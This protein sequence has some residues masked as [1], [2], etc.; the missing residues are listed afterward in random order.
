[1]INKIVVLAVLLVF[2]ICK[3]SSAQDLSKIKITNTYS[4]YL[5]A[6]LLDIGSKSHVKFSYDW[7]AIHQFKFDGK[8]VNAP[9]DSILNGMCENFNLKYNIDDDIISITVKKEST[10]EEVKKEVIIEDKRTY[11]GPPKTFNYT[12]SGKVTDGNTGEAL[13]YAAI[14][15]PGTSV[16]A[17]TNTDGYF[18]LLK[19]PTDTSALTIS[20]MGYR[21]RKYFLTPETSKA[22]LVIEILPANTQLSTV[23]VK[24]QREELMRT[25]TDVGLV[26]ISP[27]KIESLPSLGE[28]DIM[29]SL[30][31]MPGITASK[32]SSSG[33]YVWGGTPDQNLILYDGFTVYHV[34]HLYGFFS[35]FNS[36]AIKD[37]QL[38]KGGFES[39]F[40]GRLSSVTEI[41]GKD[42]NQKKFNIGGDISLLSY[43]AYIETPIGK[44]ITFL[45]AGRKSWKGPLYNEIFK[46]FNKSYNS[47]RA[48]TSGGGYGSYGNRN[49]TASTITS[50]FYDLNSKITYRP[51]DK[52][53]LSLSLYNGTDNLDNSRKMSA[54]SFMQSQGITFN[55][56]NSDLTKSGNLGGSLKWS[57]KWSDYLY[58][59]TLISYSNY[60]YNRNRSNSMTTTNS[61]G[62]TKTFQSGT[63]ETNNLK[64]YSF[65]SDYQ[66]DVFKNNKIEFGGF[67]TY[68]D[69]SYKYSQNDTTTILSR[70]DYGTNGG[71]YL[72]D[73][74]QF[75][76]NKLTLL[77]GVRNTYYS[78]TNKTY[79]EPRFSI[80]YNLTNK[81]Q[82]KGAIGQYYQF[83]NKVSFED[84][85][86]GNTE[87]WLLSNNG[88]VPVGSAT[89]YVLG[90]SYE[91][92]DY[93]FSVEGYYKDL[94]GLTE[95]TLR[96]NPHP[97]SSVNYEENF[98]NGTNNSKGIEFLAQKK[99]GN[100]NGWVSYTLG[101]SMDNFV[102]FSN[103]AYPS[104][105]DVRNEFHIVGMYKLKR[106]EF[107]ITWI[108][109]TGSPYTAPEGGYQLTL[110]NGTPKDFINVGDKN[111]LRLPDYHRLDIAANFRLVNS[112]G[113]DKGY[114]GVSIFNVYNRKNVWYKQFQI[115]NNTI[116]ETNVNYLGITP[117]LTLSLKIR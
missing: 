50:Y 79:T 48:S 114:I 85:L 73:K 7:Y 68:N 53:I 65:K 72:Q 14:G 115:V 93:L 83:V 21:I 110:L 43:N 46:E 113:K 108:Y 5:D 74:I 12:V 19:V 104:D 54:P 109:A 31:L 13:P 6:V 29:R 8:F 11:L 10:P 103:K 62:E 28:K 71:V 61:N 2:F 17:V 1:M 101:Q 42:G 60:Y 30:Q 117:N 111:S 44:K 82:L 92:P 106:W 112:D 98:F 45:I 41:T 89:H 25:S 95:Y 77:P 88:N 116:L 55:S 90:T 16:S 3:S 100:F 102:A 52:D 96:I 38:Y 84:I 75:F 87:M 51:T 22:N 37:I 86:A 63:I 4:D 33:L 24:G 23:E 78:P 80:N 94:H 40:G 39:R 32:E 59:N 56:D 70:R 97:G 49:S 18:T 47:T 35:A 20:Y 26:Q 99:A 81:L 69:I 57:R 58:G 15:I 36:N 107:S 64:D 27:R 66:L 91:T 34:D 76:K 9:L 105:Q 67:A